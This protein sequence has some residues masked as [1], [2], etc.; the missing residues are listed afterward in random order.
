MR[1]SNYTEP[2]ITL[3]EQFVSGRIGVVTVTYNSEMVLP[4]FLRSLEQQTC[5]DFI[6]FAIDNA[7]DDHT[8]RNLQAWLDS[9]LV[10]ITNPDN[11]GVAAGNNQG[12]RAAVEAGCEYVMLLNNDVVFG[13][14]LF[15]QL[16]NGLQ[17]HNC[18]MTTPMMYY[19]DRPNIIWAAGG[20]FQPWLGYR[21]VHS[22]HGRNDNGKHLKPRRTQY[23]PTCCVLLRREVFGRIGLMDVRYF[24]YCDDTDFLLRASKAG[25]RMYLVPDAKLWHKVGSLT[26]SASE[27][28]IRFNSRNRAFFLVKFL[29]RILSLPFTAAYRLYYVAR[30]LAGIDNYR[31]LSLKQASWTNGSRIPS[32]W[33]PL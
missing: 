2:T 33:W 30:Y 11:L 3:P 26:G 15:Q 20:H 21:C 25:E 24:V 23:A 29:G 18:E 32:N 4:D 5:T 14:E 9:R 16:A 13:P 27:F 12:I 31:V 1:A 28:S 6:L 10:L 17:E 8:V 7:S 22:G 19:H